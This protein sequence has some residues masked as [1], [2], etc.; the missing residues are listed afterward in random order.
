MKIGTKS[1]LFGCHQFILHP[2][3]VLWGWIKLYGLPNWKELVCVVIHDWGYW[4]LA[5]MD[6]KEG[7]EHPKWAAAKAWGCL[8]SDDVCDSRYANICLYHSRFLA[9]KLGKKPSKLCWADKKGTALMPA[10]LW[11]SLGSLSGEINEYLSCKKYEIY[12]LS[13]ANPYQFFKDYKVLIGK[14]LKEQGFHAD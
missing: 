1:L 7:E 6:G 10:W 9:K 13:K 14:L 2:L 8:D 3:F 4:G 5:D 11:V 12:G